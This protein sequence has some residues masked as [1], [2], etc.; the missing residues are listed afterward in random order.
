MKAT[1]F[2]VAGSAIPNRTTATIATIEA[3]CAPSAR[4][5]LARNEVEPDLLRFLEPERRT[6]EHH[7]QPG[8]NGQL[9]CPADR[10][11][12][13]VPED[14]LNDERDEHHAEQAGDDVFGAAPHPGDRRG[15]SL[16]HGVLR[17]S[18]DLLIT[19]PLGGLSSLETTG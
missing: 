6:E 14:D 7:V 19:R 18:P 3:D 1:Y 9:R 8:H 10:K 15:Y 11:I 12:E 5:Q 17:S 4:P 13:E 2:K 16:A